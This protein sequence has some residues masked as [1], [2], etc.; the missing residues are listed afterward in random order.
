MANKVFALC[1]ILLIVSALPFTAMAH[2]LDSEQK[3]SISLTLVSQDGKDFQDGG[4]LSL[5]YVA[6]VNVGDDG[7]LLYFY[8][9]EF[10][11]CGFLLDDSALAEKL[12]SYVSEKSGSCRKAFTDS[13]GAVRWDELPLGLYFVMQTG[14]VDGF[15]PCT[16]FLVTVPMQTAEGFVYDVDASPKT[17]VARLVTI[18]IQKV[19]NTDKTTPIPRNVMVRLLRG[20]KVL[21]TE[22]LDS[23][24]DWKV[25]LEDLPES[26]VYRVQEI[27]VAKG[28]TATYS[29]KGYV[30]VVTN[31]SSLAQTGQLI[32]PIPVLVV[33]GMFLLMMGFVILRKTGKNHG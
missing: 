27:D 32:W 10:S 21:R 8:T 18:T 31:T 12:E 11:D 22:I 33:A 15:A 26:D 28:F 2:E 29:Q 17:E 6:E 30:F 13:Q 25:V 3:G 4:E 1:V 23:S 24:N 20:D 19:W 5:Y 9:E 7:A 14:T 16:S